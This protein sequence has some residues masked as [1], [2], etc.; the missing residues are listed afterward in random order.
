MAVRGR[1]ARCLGEEPKRV[2]AYS[3]I[4]GLLIGAAVAGWVLVAYTEAHPIEVYSWH[5]ADRD[6]PPPEGMPFVGAWVRSGRLECCL[7]RRVDSRYFEYADAP[8]S[9]AA[10]YGYLPP[11]WW[12]EAP[13]QAVP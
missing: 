6:G 12:V 4:L 7:A 1:K 13:G 10:F 3:L 2:D 9:S 11:A 8:M 5:R